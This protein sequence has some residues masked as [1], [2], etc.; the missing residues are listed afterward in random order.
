MSVRLGYLYSSLPEIYHHYIDN[1]M[2]YIIYC[3][4]EMLANAAANTAAAAAADTAADTAV[5][6]DTAAAVVCAA[7]KASPLYCIS[8][9]ILT[10]FLFLEI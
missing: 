6:A 3:Y 1:I 5:A 4:P 8:L 10:V 2:V 7:E 9:P